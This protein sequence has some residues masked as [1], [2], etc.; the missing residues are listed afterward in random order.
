VGYT[1]FRADD[2][3]FTPPSGG[4]RTRA[5]LRLSDALRSMRANVWRMPAGTRGRRHIEL[6]QEELFVTL[7]GT[8]ILLVG[9]PPERVDLPAGSLLIVE[10]QTPLQ[11]A[12]DSD[13]DA[14]VLIVGAPPEQG[15]V[16]YL[17][18]AP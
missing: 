16:E 18:D 15:R 17:P 14:L 8:A 3:A 5:V 10:P 4:D 7:S 2:A 12:N 11:L 6:V 13:D 1:V 9:D